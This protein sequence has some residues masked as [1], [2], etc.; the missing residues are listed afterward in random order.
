M[1]FIKKNEM[2]E[3]GRIIGKYLFP[4][5]LTL[6]GLGL[7]IMSS[8][9]TS[10]FVVGGLGIFLVGVVSFLYIKGLISK[11]VQLVLSIVF[12]IGAAVYSYYD[13]E[14]INDELVYQEKKEKVDTHVEQRLKDIRNAQLAY[15][16]E[17]GEYAATFDS[18]LYF[19]KEGE[20][21]IIKRLGSLP[22]SVPTEDMARELGIIDT[23]PPGMTDEDIIEAGLIIRD[24][25]Q[26]GVL[27][28]VFDEDDAKNRKTPFYV[29]S[30]PY[31]PFSD[32]KFEMKAD[33]ID[34]GGVQQ[35][36]FLV[37]DPDP[38][39]FPFML[40]SLTEASTSGNWKD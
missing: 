10:L 33:K 3:V 37:T 23:I 36:V 5:F 25:V 14:V 8:G 7:M 9:Q 15:V 2:Q 27:N 1:P 12:L 26:V 6:I 24:T 21:T 29:D 30:L 17:N 38:F 22:D 20:L 34:A 40:G 11:T 31:V 16:K 19:L 35:P 39:D 32:H 4:L 18:L 13:Y 28:Y